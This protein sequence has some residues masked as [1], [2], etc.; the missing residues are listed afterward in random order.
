MSLR[1][2]VLSEDGPGGEATLRAMVLAA[3]KT[4]GEHVDTRPDEMITWCRIS[5]RA[6]NLFNMIFKEAKPSRDGTDV[7]REIA[8]QLRSGG[9]D[10]VVA[11]VDADRRW[12]EREASPFAGF[13]DTRFRAR[14]ASEATVDGS[15]IVG[16][17]PHWEIEAW[18]YQNLDALGQIVAKKGL[19][20]PLAAELETWRA[21]R[22]SLDEVADPSDLPPGKIHNAELSGV[23]WPWKAVHAANASFAHSA[24]ALCSHPLVRERL[25]WPA[26][27]VSPAQ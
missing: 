6:R 11:H 27:V 23:G 25:G 17:I 21:D 14:I 20:G 15:R 18:T 22:A 1:V 2:L 7:R 16:F 24:N 26:R 4:S 10:L 3:L 9:A 5:D 19:P 12:S 13:L 8:E